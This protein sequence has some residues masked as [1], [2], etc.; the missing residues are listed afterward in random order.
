MSLPKSVMA[1]EAASSGSRVAGRFV[2]KRAG[3]H[4]GTFEFG[5]AQPFVPVSLPAIGNPD[6]WARAKQMGGYDVSGF[7]CVH[8]NGP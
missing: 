3:A 1:I 4:V 7:G 5:I 8:L 6:Q 2:A